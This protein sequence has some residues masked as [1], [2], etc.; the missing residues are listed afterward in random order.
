M[1]SPNPAAASESSEGGRAFLQARVALFWKVMFFIILLSS[2]LGA[3]GAIARP[4][5]DFWLVLALTAQAGALWWICARGQRSVRFSRLMES[6]SLL[7]TGSR[8]RNLRHAFC[9]RLRSSAP[10]AA[11][12][13]HGERLDDR[14]EARRRLAIGAHDRAKLGLVLAEQVGDGVALTRALDDVPHLRHGIRAHFDDANGQHV[15]QAAFEL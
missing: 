2:G 5:V 8:P 3:I 13:R 14:D 9:A 6:G 7:G 12:L 11:S 4:G 1:P 10:S 15:E